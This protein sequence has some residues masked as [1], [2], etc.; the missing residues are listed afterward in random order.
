MLRSAFRHVKF[1]FRMHIVLDWDGTIT[2][3]DTMS[4]LGRI[5]TRHL[6]EA[7]SSNPEQSWEDI[8]DAYVT[9]YRSHVAAYI[10][11]VDHRKSVADEIAWLKSLESIEHAS[12]NRVERAGLFK[13]V[14]AKEVEEV[15]SEAVE[16]GEIELRV[17][18]R[19]IFLQAQQN[20]TV[21]V[22]LLSVNWSEYFIR[23]CLLK[24]ASLDTT[25]DLEATKSLESIIQGTKILANEI[26]DLD[27]TQGSSGHLNRVTGDSGIRT[28]SDKLAALEQ[29]RFQSPPQYK[30][31]IVYVGDSATDLECLLAADNG[32]IMRDEPM[33]S[34]Q[35]ELS[36][37]LERVGIETQHV[38]EP[39]KRTE[40]RQTLYWARDF[41][42]I[43]RFLG[44]HR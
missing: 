33:G 15:A 3:K 24:A 40:G 26:Q 6:A 37:T 5:A 34:G 22:S 36:E 23:S 8:V 11:S 41:L 29:L 42:E 16:G 44:L 18:W 38:D 7:G 25:S 20:E 21:T 4:F 9:D 32:I 30:Q 28:S 1:P 17:G 43:K 35:R 14:T 13:G 12:T 19:D 39:N 10:P 31:N 2:K 27:G